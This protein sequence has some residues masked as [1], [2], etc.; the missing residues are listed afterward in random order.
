M[1]HNYLFN[2]PRRAES[3]ISNEFYRYRAINK[4]INYPFNSTIKCLCRLRPTNDGLMLLAAPNVTSDL[5]KQELILFTLTEWLFMVPMDVGDN[6]YA[7][8]LLEE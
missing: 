6:N 4:Q 5:P 3:T 2:A 1:L 7:S 8:R